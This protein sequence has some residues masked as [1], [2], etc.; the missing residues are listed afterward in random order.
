MYNLPRRL[1]SARQAAKNIAV[2]AYSLSG[3]CDIAV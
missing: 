3:V 1:Q 2:Y